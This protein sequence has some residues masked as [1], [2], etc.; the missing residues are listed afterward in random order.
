MARSPLRGVG[1]EELTERV[2]SALD[3]AVILL[4]EHGG[5]KVKR[6][7][8]IGMRERAEMIGAR[9]KI[10]SEPGKG[11]KVSIRLRRSE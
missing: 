8:L 3:K 4:R 5:K 10:S 11:T 2:R 6:L 9:F 1:T 7:G